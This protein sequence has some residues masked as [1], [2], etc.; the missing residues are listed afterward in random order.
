MNK[1]EFL[2]TSLPHRLKVSYINVMGKPEGSHLYDG[3]LYHADYIDF[4][5]NTIIPIVRHMDDLTKPCVQAD[6]NNGKPFIPIVELAK[7]AGLEELIE[8]KKEN[9]KIIAFSW[10]R[11]G[12]KSGLR[13]DLVYNIEH[14]QFN[15]TLWIGEQPV[16]QLQLFQQLIKWHFDLIDEDCEKVYVNENF[17]PYK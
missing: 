2:A 13:M 8:V 16:N 4:T 14:K 10:F 12:K 11:N 17:N 5:F 1:I 3:E 7:M 6:Y 9:D 15:K